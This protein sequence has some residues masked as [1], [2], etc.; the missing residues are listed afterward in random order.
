MILKG[1]KGFYLF[2]GLEILYYINN[3]MVIFDVLGY[4]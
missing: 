4:M 3:I 1:V 2:V